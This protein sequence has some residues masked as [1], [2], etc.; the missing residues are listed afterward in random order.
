MDPCAFQGS[1]IYTKNSRTHRATYRKDHINEGM[2]GW[3]EGGREGGRKEGRKEIKER[4]RVDCVMDGSERQA[5]LQLWSIIG[6]SRVKLW[7]G[8]GI[9]SDISPGI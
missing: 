2:D 5:L 6:S 9:V 3:R 8:T 4:V 7:S 1:L